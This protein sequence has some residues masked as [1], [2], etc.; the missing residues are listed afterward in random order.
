MSSYS[1]LLENQE[2]ATVHQLVLQVLLDY[3]DITF[4]ISPAH[5]MSDIEFEYNLHYSRP[6]QPVILDST[7][8]D[9][10]PA[11]L[12]ESTDENKM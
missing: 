4:Q 2:A 1:P 9:S 3:T 6:S 12:L 5:E 11:S 8:C 10:S 7:G